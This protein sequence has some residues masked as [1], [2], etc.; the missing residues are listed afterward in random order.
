[1]FDKLISR[2]RRGDGDSSVSREDHPIARLRHD[3]DAL[4]DRFWSDL[5]MFDSQHV[6]SNVNLEDTEKE[7]V[8][9]AELPGFEPDDFDVKISGNMLTL[10][11]EH[12]EEGEEKTGN[13]SYRRYGSYYQSFTLPSGVIADKVDARYYSGILEVHLPKS[14]ECQSK[15]IEVTAA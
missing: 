5:S 14:E 8:L 15:R 10:K 13:G 9:H 2:K 6:G 7:Y 1:M 4:W 3:I 11:A 12:K